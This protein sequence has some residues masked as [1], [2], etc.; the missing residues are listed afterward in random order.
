MTLTFVTPIGTTPFDQE[1]VS[2]NQNALPERTIDIREGTVQY[3]V[4]P[5]DPSSAATGAGTA[6]AAPVIVGTWYYGFLEHI[7]EYN[8]DSVNVDGRCELQFDCID[9]G[10]LE[11]NAGNFD[12]FYPDD[13]DQFE[14]PSIYYLYLQEKEAA[15]A[16]SEALYDFLTTLHM[17]TTQDQNQDHIRFVRELQAQDSAFPKIVV[18]PRDSELP[19]LDG[20]EEH[21][22]YALCVVGPGAGTTGLPMVQIERDVP[23]DWAY[24]GSETGK[25]LFISKLDAALDRRLSRIFSLDFV[26]DVDLRP[27]DD[28]AELILLPEPNPVPSGDG[29][30]GVPLPTTGSDDRDGRDEALFPILYNFAVEALVDEGMVTKIEL[31]SDADGEIGAPVQVAKKART[32]AGPDASA[33]GGAAGAYAEEPWSPDSDS[34]PSVIDFNIAF[35]VA[36]DP[37]YVSDEDAPSTLY[38]SNSDDDGAGDFAGS[39]TDSDEDDT[40]EGG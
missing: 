36:Y 24:E 28:G 34:A 11:Y 12:A 29:P 23:I 17:G 30:K 9:V 37:D 16:R 19:I 22:W 21:C 5:S 10:W 38:D 35:S 40:L 2:G 27:P 4:A 8:H 33:A 3:T 15:D 26:P 7:E 32:D 18:H 14:E 31:Q 1:T 25:V 6:N 39:N 20:F 13:V